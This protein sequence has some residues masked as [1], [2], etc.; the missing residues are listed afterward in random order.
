MKRQEKLDKLQDK[1]IDTLLSAEEL[2]D[3]QLATAIILLKN[4]KIVE[5][6]T[7]HSEADLIDELTEDPR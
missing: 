1:V 5:D 4:N 2:S 7:I 6:K 3:K